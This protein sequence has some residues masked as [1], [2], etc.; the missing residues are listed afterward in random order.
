[1]ANS[2]TA[3]PSTPGFV[4][5]GTLPPITMEQ[6]KLA[7]QICLRRI[8]RS[9]H[10]TCPH[11]DFIPLALQ[12]GRSVHLRLE[13]VR[14]ANGFALRMAFG[15]VNR[16]DVSEVARI[17]EDIVRTFSAVACALSET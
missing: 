3:R 15:H 5:R 8:S 9:V 12:S 4:S 16:N 11:G 13:L 1:M 17:R 14:V 7:L 2:Q 10:A 6:A